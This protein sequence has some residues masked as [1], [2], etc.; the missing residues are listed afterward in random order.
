MALQPGFCPPL[1]LYNGSKII[2]PSFKHYTIACNSPLS[3]WLITQ[4][5]FT[6]THEMTNW[7]YITALFRRACLTWVVVGFKVAR[8]TP[9]RTR[10]VLAVLRLPLTAS[11][12]I[13][14][15]EWRP[16]PLCRVSHHLPSTMSVMARAST[17]SLSWTLVHLDCFLPLR[18]L[19]PSL[20]CFPFPNTKCTTGCFR[21]SPQP[22]FTVAYRCAFSGDL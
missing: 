21:V 15:W 17:S 9:S 6:M 10:R 14:V 2:F 11:Y 1:V 3:P 19:S 8:C 16:S 20:V 12:L 5:E 4:H 7:P 13:M 22:C 18:R